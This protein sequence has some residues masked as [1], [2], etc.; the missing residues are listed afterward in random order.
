MNFRAKL[1]L[2]FFYLFLAVAGCVGP[3]TA[4][5]PEHPSQD[6]ARFWPPPP[7]KPRI[8]Y[9]NS[10]SSSA[11]LGVKKTWLARTMETMFGKEDSEEKMLRPYGVFA[12]NGRVYVTDPGAH[13]LHV[14]DIQEKKYFQVG[15]A[16]G[17][18]LSSPI[19]VAADKNG[20]IYLSDSMLN[21]V[22]VFD[23]KGVYLREIGS[24]NLFVRPAGLAV[25]ESRVYVV[26]T[27]G[28]QALVFAKKD[29]DLLFNFGKNG[30][31]QGDFNFPTN[32]FVSR[33]GLMYIMDSMNFRVQVFGKDG[34]FI[35][36]FGKLGD[37]SG[38]FSK[39]KGIAVDSEG[40]IYVADSHF[41]GV[42]IFGLDGTLLLSFGGSGRGVGEML[43]PAGIF[44]DEKDR[45]YVADSYNARVQIF[46]YLKENK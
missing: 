22:L 23:S 12:D 37:G 32:I 46:Q 27:H 40:H 10:L 39:A 36:A 41:D 30:V 31:G 45:I 25:D 24:R 14:F 38:D 3:E 42:Q 29:G 34:D 17:E 9:L 21:R 18:K 16:K 8:Q 4:S 33:D 11:D 15:A 6:V 43:L 28:H 5:R 2:L 7:Q 1:L 35:S 19:G 20:D 26:D 44:I 13:L